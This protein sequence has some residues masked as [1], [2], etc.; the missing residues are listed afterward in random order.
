MYV[1]D[2]GQIVLVGPK[3]QFTVKLLLLNNTHTEVLKKLTLICFVKDD[4]LAY[5][6]LFFHPNGVS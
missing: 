6:H 3:Y 1:L 2:H 5:L 4:W